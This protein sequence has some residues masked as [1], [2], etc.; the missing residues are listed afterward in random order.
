MSCHKPYIKQIQHEGKV[1]YT[2]DL[3]LPCGKCVYCRKKRTADWV[4]RLESEM[5]RSETAYVATLTYSS[6]WLPYSKT[7]LPTLV[8]S[9]KYV[10]D[11]KAK[12]L[13][14]SI[15]AFMKRLRYYESVIGYDAPIRFY[16]VGEY[17]KK[18]R[19]PH[20]HVIL[21]NVAD[22]EHIRKSWSYGEI[23]VDRLST[24][25]IVYCLKYLNKERMIPEFEGDDRVPEF[26][27]MSKGLGDNFLTDQMI[28]YY[29]EN[30]VLYVTKR[31]GQKVGLPRYYKEAIWPPDDP[32]RDK[33]FM[34]MR[35]R[36]N[37]EFL[38]RYD[39]LRLDF[40]Y[41]YPG[42]PTYDFTQYLGNLK[43]GQV[44]LHK[45]KINTH[46]KND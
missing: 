23:Y 22:P 42:H 45:F 21:F 6:E 38:K 43:E 19:R 28:R 44:L 3:Q 26:A 12:N 24:A 7:G 33:V 35:E 37:E 20:Y 41:K 18:R 16:A 27:L 1:R 10:V 15:P 30:K 5:K 36:M 2:E 14:A 46:G 40:S 25:S 34:E 4:L 17:G 32:D 39:E 9:Q 29:R 11:G 31:G 8:K 13:E